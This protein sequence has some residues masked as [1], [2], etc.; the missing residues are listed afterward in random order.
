MS[1]RSVAVTPPPADIPGQVAPRFRWPPVMVTILAIASCIALGASTAEQP[2]IAVAA[3]VGV[4]LAL[5]AAIRPEVATLVV[6]FLLYSNAAVVAVT[7]FEAPLIVGAIVPMILVVPLGYELLIKRREVIITPAFPWIM[8]YFLVQI[9]GT[10]FAR[11]VPAAAGELVNFVLEGLGLYL[12][13]INA[14]R[15]PSAMRH[16][17]WT[18][19]AVG[20]LLGGLS[21]VQ[22]ATG[23]YAS[24]YFG[25]AQSDATNDLG[26]NVG[27]D[28]ARLAGPIGEKNRYAQ[29]MLMLVP[30]ALFQA[31]SE[32]RRLL[33]LAAYGVALLVSGAV[34][35]T[36]SRGAAV[37]FVLV[38][39]L[40]TVLRYIKLYQL[41]AVGLVVVAVLIA[42]PQYTD[43]LATLYAV[44]GTVADSDSAVSADNSVLSRAT[45]N[46]AAL[47]VFSDYPIVGVGPGQFSSYYR[48]Y[49][50]D[51]AISVRAED[52][53]A[54]N[55]Y[56][57]T[58]A[59]TGVLGLVCFVA[60]LG[61]T[62]WQLAL[63]RRRWLGRRPDLANMVTGFGLAL[64][65]YMTTGIFLHLSYIR[66]FWLVMALAGAAALIAL[67]EPDPDGEDAI[68]EAAARRG[69]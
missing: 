64:V 37:G 12:L 63:A 56:L 66:Y 28:I 24:D 49:A 44:V 68:R 41:A 23:T 6:V 18:L 2:V 15:T 40:M 16:V 13:V 25:F 7:R 60:I 21:I 17:I 39:V 8:A 34:I 35:L 43:R 42:V 27:G 26:I 11:D 61:I 48:E 47:Y 4:L 1:G 53:Q 20:A 33:R 55:L 54:H 29:I 19:L 51:I 65:T 22:A 30:L 3:L 46:L 62:L 50:D 59:E 57:S 10:L 32:R 58:A 9:V 67:R 69:A 38:V 52:R 14:V 45:E 5:A 31:W 36:F